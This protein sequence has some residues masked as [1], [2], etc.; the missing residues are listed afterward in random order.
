M[1]WKTRGGRA[2]YYE[3]EREGDRVRSRYIGSGETAPLS[4]SQSEV[5]ERDL[6]QAGGYDRKA[7]CDKAERFSA[8]ID[9]ACRLLT[10]T[11]EAI[12]EADGYHRHHRGPWRR[13]RTMSVETLPA[14]S[15]QPASELAERYQGGEA[16]AREEIRAFIDKAEA[17]DRQAAAQVAKMIQAIPRP[18]DIIAPDIAKVVEER[19]IRRSYGKDAHASM[20]A[21]RYRLASLRQELAGPSPSAVERLLAERAAL[22][23]LDCYFADYL[24]IESKDQSFR[25]ADYNARE[26]DRAHRRQPSS[27]AGFGEEAADRRPTGQPRRWPSIGREGRGPAD[28][29]TGVSA[30]SLC[31]GPGGWG[32]FYALQENSSR[33]PSRVTPA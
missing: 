6:P 16:E 7:K 27:S 3:S 9:R 30:T 4:I 19:L 10:V 21:V 2:Y 31:N 12:L 24:A 23:W 33:G 26:R 20:E 13:R 32:G 18:A 17:G 1:P 14:K 11:A 5:I 25:Q 28:R 8:R 29:I 22:C 15:G